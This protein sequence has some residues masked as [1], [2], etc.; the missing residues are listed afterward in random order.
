MSDNA[1]RK[2]VTFVAAFTVDAS[3]VADGFM[4]TDEKAKNMLSHAL[5]GAHGSEIAARVIFTSE[6]PRDVFRQYQGFPA[7]EAA[8]Q[9]AGYSKDAPAH[10]KLAHCLLGC[11]VAMSAH[12][13]TTQAERTALKRLDEMIALIQPREVP[14]D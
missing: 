1:T 2:P 7:F 9:G 10:Y 5:H 11:K 8:K 12:R 4:L 3:W 13:K 14:Q 6:A